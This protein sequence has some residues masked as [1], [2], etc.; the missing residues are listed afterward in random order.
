MYLSHRDEFPKL[1]DRLEI[2]TAAEIGVAAGWF[3]RVLL[4]AKSL[5]KLYLI[6]PW[7]NPADASYR[8]KVYDLAASDPRVEIIE[9]TSETAVK[10]FA[11]WSLDMVYHDS[12]HEYPFMRDELPRWWNKVT[13]LYSGHDYVLWNHAVNIPVGVMLAVEEF[14]HAHRQAVYVTGAE[15]PDYVS[16]L[17]AASAAAALPDG[18][19]FGSHYPS[20]YIFKCES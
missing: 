3:S 5:E 16:R 17:R 12:L 18:G 20:W 11:D 1:L 19:A 10:R 7:P 14:A 4:Q 6:D 15:R 9:E 8:Q 2:K 13:K